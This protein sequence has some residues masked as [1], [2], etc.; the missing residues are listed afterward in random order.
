ML[1]VVRQRLATL[2]Y[3]VRLAKVKNTK[4][5]HTIKSKADFGNFQNVINKPNNFVEK[6]SYTRV[7]IIIAGHKEIVR[8]T[9]DKNTCVH[10]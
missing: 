9:I 3:N 1:R 8:E 6:N 7:T 10:F 2:P 5:L 4:N